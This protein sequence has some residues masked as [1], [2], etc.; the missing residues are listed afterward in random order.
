M[1]SYLG[2]AYIFIVIR[3]LLYFG[4]FVLL[5]ILLMKFL[6]NKYPKFTVVVPIVFVVIFVLG[7]N[8]YFTYI[9]QQIQEAISQY[10]VVSTWSSD[11]AK[12]MSYMY[13]DPLLNALKYLVYICI[14]AIP[15]LII[16]YN[17]IK[18]YDY[19]KIKELKRMKIQDL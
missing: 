1:L 11:Y 2:F 10:Q 9:L 19:R 18:R 3:A 15:V 6:F 17:Y 4:G 5:G 7:S 8:P 13:T 14:R 12:H 16:V